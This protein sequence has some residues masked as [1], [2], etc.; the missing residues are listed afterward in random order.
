MQQFTL[1]MIHFVFRYGCHNFIPVQ[2]ILCPEQRQYKF[3]VF[4]QIKLGLF[5]LTSK[6][7]QKTIILSLY[8]I[9][10]KNILVQKY[11]DAV[12]TLVNTG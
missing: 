1:F 4:S 5:L 8:C 6:I 10:S 2:L 12:T 3:Y 11:S 7:P 9:V